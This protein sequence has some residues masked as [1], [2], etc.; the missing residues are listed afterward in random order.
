[1][2]P[3]RLSLYALLGLPD[4]AE[5]ARVLAAYEGA[6]ASAANRSDWARAKQLSAAF[7]RLP[8]DVRLALYPGR[9]RNARR[10]EPTRTSPA[11]RGTRASRPR[12]GL[13]RWRVVVATVFVVAVALAAAFGTWKHLQSTTST[14]PASTPTPLTVPVAPATRPAGTAPTPGRSS[15]TA[16]APHRS[17]APARIIRPT[18]DIRLG[19]TGEQIGGLPLWTTP[20]GVPLD[21][22]GNATMRCAGPLA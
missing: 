4:E 11:A 15:A 6:M 12:Q 19:N 3:D 20:P 18:G 2:D 22:R 8:A 14:T 10:W 16:S 13:F 7:D 9:E 1:M 21:P 17:T 5:I